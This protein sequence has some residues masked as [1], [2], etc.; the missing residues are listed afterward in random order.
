MI[1]AAMREED[2]GIPQ[3]QSRNGHAVAR[4]PVGRCDVSAQG[5]AIWPAE[6]LDQTTERYLGCKQKL[7]Q[8]VN[9]DLGTGE[10]LRVTAS[11]PTSRSFSRIHGRDDNIL[12]GES[13]I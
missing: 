9:D 3:T 4:I 8:A 7:R 10:T 1:A 11:K 5:Y 2:S 13:L 6:R 12:R